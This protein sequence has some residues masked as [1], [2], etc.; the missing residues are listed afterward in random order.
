MVGSGFSRNAVLK[1]PGCKLPPTWTE[2]AETMRSRLT[3]ST[4]CTEGSFEESSN[5]NPLITAQL[6][7]DEFGRAEF[8]CFLR[9][10][11]GDDD[12]EPSD[13]HSRLL[14]LPWADV[15][16][17]NWDT[18]LERTQEQIVS[19]QYDIVRARD[20]LPL[21]SRPRIVKLHGSLPAHF[22]LVATS[23]DYEEYPTKFAPFVNTAR[24]A[25]MES[26]FLLIGFSGDDPNFRSWLEWVKIELDTSAPKIYLAGWL[27]LDQASIRELEKLGVAPI[28]LVHHPKH[29]Q[30]QQQNMKHYLATEWLIASLEY[31]QPYPLEQWPKVL[32]H[33]SVDIPFLLNPLDKS[34]WCAPRTPSAL[35]V[36]DIEITRETVDSIVETWK[37]NREL[38]PGWLALPAQL[39]NDLWHINFSNRSIDLFDTSKEDQIITAV[40]GFQLTER[41]QIVA[42]VVWRREIRLEPLGDELVCIGKRT[43]RE[44]LD[45]GGDSADDELDR[46]SANRIALAVV[47]HARLKFDQREFEEAVYIANKFAQ[48]DK[49][50]NHRLSYERCLWALYQNEF[51]SLRQLMDDWSVDSGDPY[52]LVRKS[53][54][55]FE[56]GHTHEQVLMLL[57]SAIDSLRK[58]RQNSRDISVLSREAWAEVLVRWIDNR[59]WSG[60]DG[61]APHLVRAYDK[62]RFNCDPASEIRALTIAIQSRPSRIK[63]P[64]FELGEGNRPRRVIELEEVG[65]SEYEEKYKAQVAYRIVRLVELVGLPRPSDPQPHIQAI[66]QSACEELHRDGQVELSLRLLLRVANNSC[67]ELILRLLSRPNVACLPNTTIESIGDLCDSVIDEYEECAES[68]NSRNLNNLASRASVAVELLARLSIRFSTDRATKTVRRGLT[69]YASPM[70][71]NDMS[72]RGPLRNLLEWSWQA[73]PNYKKSHLTFEILNSPIPGVDGYSPETNVVFEPIAL[74]DGDVDAIPARNSQNEQDWDST[75]AFLLRAL[76]SGD[77][78]VFPAISRLVQ[79]AL[80]PRL[81]QEEHKKLATA[82]WSPTGDHR[83]VPVG[84]EVLR[85]WVYFLLPEP[86]KGHTE[87]WFRSKYLSEAVQSPE[88]DELLD[89]T[90]YHVGEVVDLAR[91]FGYS[92]KLSDEDSALIR[93]NLQLWATSTI[94]Q[95]VLLPF[96]HERRDKVRKGIR[97]VARLLM[98]LQLDSTLVESLYQK[99][100]QLCAMNISA[101]PI[102]IGLLRA[103]SAPINDIHTELRKR[104]SSRSENIVHD[105]ALAI[106]HWLD[107]RDLS[108]VPLPSTDLIR[109]IGVIIA[110][111]RAIA[112]SPALSVAEWVFTNGGS[113]DQQELRQLCLEGLSYLIEELDYKRKQSDDMDVPLLRWRCVSL[114]QAMQEKGIS[115]DIVEKWLEV[116][117]TDPLPEVRHRVS[118]ANATERKSD[119]S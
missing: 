12:L 73:I 94:P 108:D 35:S 99:Y 78:A 5:P 9:D 54:L 85:N 34:S 56:L 53:C 30:W 18:L 6:Y 105:A 67:D 103:P 117:R 112:L 68:P 119:E 104:L 29:E 14:A 88:H 59:T 81:S 74:I 38:Y 58:S 64:G 39:I 23:N 71:Y 11:I 84:H 79:I 102:L 75:L 10:Q 15:F 76:K 113:A 62:V 45:L 42:E 106:E 98:H 40:E 114:A 66:L 89:D 27:N 69:I 17:T 77:K 19:P 109:E 101:M 93:V 72:F 91:T 115:E 116:A 8:H 3:T 107:S 24:Q 87:R 95:Y 61:S 65:V 36:D 37:H 1:E 44:V 90:L 48:Y 63:G 82:I 55:L 22:P 16:S 7:C 4:E 49:N 96:A 33:P 25:L 41:L 46:N 47:N 110:T 97:G 80:A 43:L 111:R 57:R 31:G 28:D 2:L 51:N 20:E 21:A 26:V 32:K 60:V 52:W 118:G 13:L 92:F 100:R 86:E 83:E 50:A 70:F